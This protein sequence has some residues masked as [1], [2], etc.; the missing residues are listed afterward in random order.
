MDVKDFVSNGNFV[1]F[2][3]FRAGIFYYSVAHKMTL[4]RF[5][6]QVPLDDIG[7]A[8]LFNRDKSIFFMRW[9]RKSIQDGTFVKID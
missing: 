2:D 9:I 4:E 1:T 7:S 3:S 6:F 8:T 5:Q